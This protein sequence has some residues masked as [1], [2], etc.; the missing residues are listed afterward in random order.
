MNLD[1]LTFDFNIYLPKLSFRGR[2]DLKIK[3]LLLNIAGTGDLKGVL[4]KIEDHLGFVIH[5]HR[6]PS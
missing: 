2:Y 5:T 6:S 1:K 4:G 3:L